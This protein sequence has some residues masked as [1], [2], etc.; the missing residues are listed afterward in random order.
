MPTSPF[1]VYRILS[2]ERFVK[3]FATSS[4][5]RFNTKPGFL[6][7]QNHPE[8]EKE[9]LEKYPSQKRIPMKSNG[10]VYGERDKPLGVPFRNGYSNK[11]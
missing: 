3:S 10:G 9:H 11:D 1:L 2:C 7:P 8:R 5:W 4:R 6:N